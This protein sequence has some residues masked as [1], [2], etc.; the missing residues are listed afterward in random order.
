[1]LE[2]SGT[3]TFELMTKQTSSSGL[4]SNVNCVRQNQ[5]HNIE[6]PLTKTS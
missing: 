1:M 3:D 4:V 2:V 6:G 5:V